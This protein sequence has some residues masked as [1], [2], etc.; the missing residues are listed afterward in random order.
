M[1]ITKYEHACMLLEEQGK[2]LLID[3]GTFTK[4]LESLPNLTAIVITH[5]HFDH[6]D[7]DKVTE[8]SKASKAPI[9]S[10]SEVADQLDSLDVTI[11]EP[12]KEYQVGPFQMTFYGEDHAP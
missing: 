10:T 12:G 7:R 6:L 11:V 5:A 3:P 8:F 1:T 9:F 4:S 2:Q